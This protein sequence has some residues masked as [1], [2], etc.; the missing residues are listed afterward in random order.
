M[1]FFLILKTIDFK[2][3]KAI[4]NLLKSKNRL[5]YS[6][7]KNQWDLSTQKNSYE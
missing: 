3:L 4:I 5:I 7:S 6:S 2:V 1:S